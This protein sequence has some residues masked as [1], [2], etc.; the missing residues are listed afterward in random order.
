MI[1]FITAFD[2]F[3]MT[4]FLNSSC[5][6]LR[7][8]FSK[9]SEIERICISTRKRRPRLSLPQAT[10]AHTKKPAVSRQ[11]VPQKTNYLKTNLLKQIKKI[12]VILSNPT[13]FNTFSSVSSFHGAKL[14]RKEITSKKIAFYFTVRAQKYQKRGMD[15]TTHP[16]VC[17][18]KFAK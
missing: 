16:S 13:C 5:Q 15:S 14:R 1:C 9:R 4:R 17:Y 12:S 18:A 7:P 2:A 11:P 3:M 10:L 8:F 6:F